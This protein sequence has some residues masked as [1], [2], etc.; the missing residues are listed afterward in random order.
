MTGSEVAMMTMGAG[1]GQPTRAASPA[2][3]AAGGSNTGP[4][5][6]SLASI[7]LTGAEGI[8]TR[9]GAM[10]GLVSAVNVDRGTV[11]PDHIGHIQQ[12]FIDTD[13]DV[14]QNIYSYLAAYQNAA[15]G[16]LTNVRTMATATVVEMADDSVPVQGANAQTSLQLLADQMRAAGQSVR[17]CLVSATIVPDPTNVGDAVGLVS[18]RDADG[19]ACEYLLNEYATATVTND[20]QS[21]P[22]V[23]G[24]EPIQVVTG[25]SVLD[26]FSYLYPGGSGVKVSLTAVSASKAGT[27]GATN[28]L[29]NGAMETF[30]ASGFL[31][32]SWHASIGTLG[33]TVLQ[34]TAV[35][36]D[37]VSSLRL[38]GNGTEHTAVYQSFS[39]P[40][41][42]F[43]TRATL[44][45]NVQYGVNFAIRASAPPGSGVLT[46]SLGTGA[47]VSSD[48]AGRPNSMTVD[49]TT[50]GTAWRTYQA[51]F[52][53]PAV[54]PTPTL[55]LRFGLTTPLPAGISIYLDHVAFT[56]L[57]P[58]YAG[59]P[60]VAIFSG[61]QALVKG[62]SFRLALFNNYGG[63]FQNFFD[64]CFGMKKLGII[65]PS[66]ATGGETIPDS[67]IH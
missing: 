33:V 54:L 35:F 6:A 2:P 63:A 22:S 48:N 52:R 57:T 42:A 5:T 39:T 61:V 24:S 14:I 65:L 49:L 36:Y 13:Q 51:T 62:D 30:D 29:A 32:Q 17:A 58:L 59:G 19:L 31:P 56:P 55:S 12:Q 41:A 1:G 50:L 23:L 38:A 27:A 28:W 10:A 21:T 8:F 3:R 43:D 60:S 53:T 26:S 4:G 7:P 37:G 18:V 66:N 9:L 11:V 45:P 67:L 20:S 47:G 44:S 15:N 25:P 46:V 64:A 16:L 40:A 34:S